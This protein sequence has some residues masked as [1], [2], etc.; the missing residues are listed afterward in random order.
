MINKIFKLTISHFN[1][2][3]KL[4]GDL[5][6]RVYFLLKPPINKRFT[7][8]ERY[9]L[10]FQIYLPFP[11]ILAEKGGMV[12]SYQEQGI[13]YSLLFSKGEFKARNKYNIYNIIMINAYNLISLLL[14]F[15]P[16]TKSLHLISINNFLFFSVYTLNPDQVH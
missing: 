10:F 4:I 14:S 2:F 11:S 13:Y 12:R 3:W 15:C 6:G 8:L 16:S 7:V 9:V 1:L 5:R